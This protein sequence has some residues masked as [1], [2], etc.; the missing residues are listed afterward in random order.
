MALSYSVLPQAREDIREAIEWLEAEAEPFTG[1]TQKIQAT[2]R[3]AIPKS[4]AAPS[5]PKK[6]PPKVSPSP[7]A[8]PYALPP[9]SASRS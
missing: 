1:K 7:D 6:P 9:D 8:P 5:P 4:T 3:A 2:N